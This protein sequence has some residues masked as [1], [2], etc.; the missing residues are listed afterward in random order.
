M[1][2]EKSS[3]IAV[4]AKRCMGGVQQLYT[5]SANVPYFMIFNSLECYTEVDLKFKAERLF[6]GSIFHF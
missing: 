5:I 3:K 4:L 6:V 1:I 2:F